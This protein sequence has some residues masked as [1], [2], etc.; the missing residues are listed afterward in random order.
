M[1]AVAPT[2]PPS[3]TAPAATAQKA[4]GASVNVGRMTY[5][6]ALRARGWIQPFDYVVLVLIA[7]TGVTLFFYWLFGQPTFR[8]VVGILVVDMFRLQIWTII[9]LFRCSCFVLETQADINLMPEA[10]GRI[11]VG[12][13]TG[14]KT[15]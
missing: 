8:N 2:A 1:I 7:L 15:K 13:L 9:L 4:Q 10:A 14:P 12:F 3:P 11:A 5:L 6:Q